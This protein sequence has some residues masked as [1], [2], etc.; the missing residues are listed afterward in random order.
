M[1]GIVG[2]INLNGQ[3]VER[4]L[5]RRLTRWLLAGR[6]PRRFGPKAR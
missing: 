2:I 3:P 1:S 4:L 5:L 6:M